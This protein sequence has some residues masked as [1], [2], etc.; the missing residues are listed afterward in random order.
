MGIISGVFDLFPT[1]F[2]LEPAVRSV[3]V[4]KGLS[5]F[6]VSLE[7]VRLNAFLLELGLLTTELNSSLK[8]QMVDK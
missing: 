2:F 5:L 4:T 7:L 1:L 6:L 3:L 8:T